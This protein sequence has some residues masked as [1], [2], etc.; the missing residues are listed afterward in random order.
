MPPAFAL[1]VKLVLEITSTEQW[2]EQLNTE[3]TVVAEFTQPTCMPC[4]KLA[5]ILQMVEPEHIDTK[6]F[7]VDV[8]QF[9]ELAGIY[10]IQSTPTVIVFKGGK[11]KEKIYGMHGKQFF[12]DLLAK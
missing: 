10:G 1:E 12:T 6:F 7:K 3:F 4:R 2:E 9:P 5:A 8:T 11:I